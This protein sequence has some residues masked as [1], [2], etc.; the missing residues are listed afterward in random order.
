MA[1]QKIHRALIGQLDV[2]ADQIQDGTI[3][4]RDLAELPL[5]T[6]TRDP[7]S[8]LITRIVHEGIVGGKTITDTEDIV[9]DPETG[10]V[11]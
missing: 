6:V 1:L 8:G 11:S 7:G 4:R 2:G 3:T 10:L 9:R 5:K